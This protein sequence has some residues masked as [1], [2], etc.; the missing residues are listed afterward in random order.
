MLFFSD[1]RRIADTI[2]ALSERFWYSLRA[3]EMPFCNRNLKR[4]LAGLRYPEDGFR[5]DGILLCGPHS[6]FAPLTPKW[7]ARKIA[8]SAQPSS[9]AFLGCDLDTRPVGLERAVSPTGTR[10]VF[11]IPTNSHRK[12]RSRA[13]IQTNRTASIISVNKWYSKRH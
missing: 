8:F 11:N 2:T 3:D 1:P 6:T 5:Q 9:S 13:R 10:L 12:S 7:S 4:R